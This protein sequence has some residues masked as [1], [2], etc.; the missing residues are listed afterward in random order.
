LEL[1]FVVMVKVTKQWFKFYGT[2][3]LANDV[4]NLID[5]LKLENIRLIGYSMG[6]VIALD[7]LSTILSIFKSRIDSH[8]WRT[9]WSSPFIFEN[10]LLVLQICFH[11]RLFPVTCQVIFL[12][13]FFKQIGLEKN[14][15]LL[16]VLQN[17]D[18]LLLKSCWNLCS[19]F[20]NKVVKRI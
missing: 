8:W 7:L 6:T 10:L 18:L 4:I 5:H 19:N 9:H 12:Y 13:I 3:N 1:I 11:M 14:L 16:L 2:T 15:W 20:N 17:T